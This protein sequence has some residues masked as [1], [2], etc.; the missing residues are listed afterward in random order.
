MPAG[1]WARRG[2]VRV[3]RV[4]HEAAS[5]LL[6]IATHE[7]GSTSIFLDEDGN[8][9]PL[10]EVS[11]GEHAAC[12]AIVTPSF[13]VIGDRGAV[14][15]L[16]MSETSCVATPLARLPRSV[17]SLGCKVAIYCG[18]L[19]DEP[20]PQTRQ[21]LMDRDT[22][23]FGDG[24]VQGKRS[25]ATA[26]GQE[27]KSDED[28]GLES[29]Q[30]AALG[31]TEHIV[32]M[33]R[34]D[35]EIVITASS[36]GIVQFWDIKNM[37]ETLRFRATVATEGITAMA[38]DQFE[39]R[40]AIGDH[41]GYV[42]IFDISGLLNSNHSRKERRGTFRRKSQSQSMFGESSAFGGMTPENNALFIR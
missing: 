34:T 42:S 5:R 35:P 9:G 11:S 6:I 14:R 32:V 17:T 36:D 10:R 21:Y 28:L 12:A 16:N 7:E 31:V 20:V 24:G 18:P 4:R 40:L 23:L 37:T 1:P 38:L 8:D 26:A 13:L 29:R 41:A 39:N 30:M 3:L 33:H 27:P 2:D 22:Y 15:V 25:D 19:I